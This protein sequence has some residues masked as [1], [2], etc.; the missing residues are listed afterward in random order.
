MPSLGLRKL[1]TTGSINANKSNWVVIDDG[2][3]DVIFHPYEENYKVGGH[4]FLQGDF[5]LI[6]TEFVIK[7]EWHSF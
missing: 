6:N 5:F 7:S 3:L 1:F 4:L 2:L